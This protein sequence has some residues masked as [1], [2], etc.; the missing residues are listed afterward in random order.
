MTR[1]TRITI[2]HAP[3]STRRGGRRSRPTGRSWCATETQSIE[4]GRRLC[5]S[6]AR[7]ERCRRF[8]ARDACSSVSLRFSV[9][10]YFGQVRGRSFRPDGRS[11]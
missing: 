1:T 9:V 6:A 5:V 2:A 7:H 8:A 3:T 4:Q 10:S 11:G